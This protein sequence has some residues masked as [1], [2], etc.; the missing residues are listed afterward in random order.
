MQRIRR[1]A[2]AESESTATKRLTVRDLPSD[3]HIASNLSA[4]LPRGGYHVLEWQRL[5]G[6]FG[7]FGAERATVATAEHGWQ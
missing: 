6:G 5:N 1:W 4:R 2:P 3:S 7:Y